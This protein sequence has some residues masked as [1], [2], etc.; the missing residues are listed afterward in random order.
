[1]SRGFTLLESALVGAIVAVA[2]FALLFALSSASHF[3]AQSGGPA[4]EAAQ[5]AAES[6]LRDAL[7]AWKYGS[8]G[9]A[10]SGSAGNVTVTLSNV[11]ATG[12][13][14]VVRASYTPD[15]GHGAQAGT[16]Q[17]SGD[18]FVKAPLPG[19]QVARPG[20]VPA[21]SASP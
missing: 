9:N 19:S 20:L 4:R 3:A 2:A 10:P 12:T 6:A 16:V 13:H 5:A 7:Q 11:T 14:I 17:I 8:P 15:P 18:A 1:M 21:P